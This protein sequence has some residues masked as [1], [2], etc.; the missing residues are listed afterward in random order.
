MESNKRKASDKKSSPI[1]NNVVWYLLAL[2]VLT[3]F[4]VSLL[5]S[6]SEVKLETHDFEQLVAHSGKNA[7]QPSYIDVHVGEG[8]HAQTVRYSEPTDIRVF[9]REIT[10]KLTREV[11]PLNERHPNPEMRQKPKAKADRNVEKD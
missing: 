11:D 1:N 3:L 4:V 7:T 9:E 6:G 8:D 10:G 2:G 5:T